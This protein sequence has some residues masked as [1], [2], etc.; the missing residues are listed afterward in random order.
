MDA[1][2]LARLIAAGR[3]GIGT[4]L[5]FAPKL[6]GRRWIGEAAD[7]RGTQVALRGLGGRDLALGIGTLL[8][9]R[10]DAPIRGWVEAGS[11]ADG[12]DAAAT[13]LAGDDLSRA[14]RVGTV[15]LAGGALVAGQ[16]IVRQL[17]G[18]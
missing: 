11:L 12:T 15:L 13:L 16:W 1:R 2:S 9:L 10:H 3:V 6:A 7:R 8:A 14:A 5:L 18:N 17:D 4:A